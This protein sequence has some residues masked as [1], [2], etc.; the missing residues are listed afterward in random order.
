MLVMGSIALCSHAFT[1]V[2]DAGHGGRDAG[3]VGN[4]V[5]EKNINL[6]VVK[7]LG[8]LI[9]KNCPGVK[10][11]Y[12]RKTDVFV[13]LDER[14]QIAN[15]AKADLF[16]SVHTNS[17]ASKRG[18]QGTETYTLGMHRAAENLE[19]AKREN[20]VITMENN[21]ERRYE[22]FDPSSSES[23]IIFELMQDMNM[24]N[25]VR[26]AKKIQK[27]F[28]T[29]SRRVDRGVFQAGF[30]VLRATSMPSVLVELGYV[31]N[32]TEAHF[33]STANGAASMAKSIY[34]GFV[35][36]KKAVCH[37]N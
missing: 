9:E 1:V 12:T 4:G 31:N 17:T 6:S 19:V 11:I 20:S 7:E 18:P 27:E 2:L 34:N 29:T 24:E 22:G 5:K 35:S 10:V 33:L 15:R 28:K 13:E 26:L 23:Y 3:A 16:I 14:A 30:L 36:Y 37:E 25:S 21:Y 32:A 8:R